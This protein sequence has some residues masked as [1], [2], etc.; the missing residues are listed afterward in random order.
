MKDMMGCTVCGDPYPI[1]EL[2]DS[3]PGGMMQCASC[4]VNLSIQEQGENWKQR[5]EAEDPSTVAVVT[6][7]PIGRTPDGR[8]IWVYLMLYGDI[9]LCVGP[10]DAGWIDDRWRYQSTN[11]GLA[12]I[13]PDIHDLLDG[14]EPSRHDRWVTGPSNY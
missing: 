7:K 3:G 4:A 8:G 10:T 6:P 11:L 13:V 5:T 9:D 2:L 12:N 14:R 1:T